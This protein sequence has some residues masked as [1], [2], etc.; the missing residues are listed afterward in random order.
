M[1]KLERDFCQHTIGNTDKLVD[2]ATCY[3]QRRCDDQRVTDCAHDQT[4]L[5]REITA[6][7]SHLEIFVEPHTTFLDE[8][9]RPHEA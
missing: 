7:L 2:F 1:T 9:Y 6:T 8:F 5:D 4:M 3:H